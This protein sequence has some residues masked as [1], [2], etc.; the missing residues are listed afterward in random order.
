MSWTAI[1][2]SLSLVCGLLAALVLYI[3][4]PPAKYP[5][6]GIVLPWHV[7]TAE[8]NAKHVKLFTTHQVPSALYRKQGHLSVVWHSKHAS[9]KK[10]RHFLKQATKMAAKSG[11]NAIIL[12]ILGHTGEGVQTRWASYRLEG[13]AV[14]LPQLKHLESEE[15][16]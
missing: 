8:V 13:E 6:S 4:A 10:E 14:Y 9:E 7:P 2:V 5:I 16:P 15:T 12:S 11:A 3:I 1:R